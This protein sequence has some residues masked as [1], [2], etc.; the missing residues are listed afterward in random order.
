MIVERKELEEIPAIPREALYE[1]IRRAG[2][3]DPW[4]SEE[5]ARRDQRLLASF[6]LLANRCSEGL[7][8]EPDD[9]HLEVAVSV[10]DEDLKAL[11]D[12]ITRLRFEIESGRSLGRDMEKQVR[13]FG[14]LFDEYQEMS[15]IRAMWNRPGERMDAADLMAKRYPQTKV[16]VVKL[17]TLKRKKRIPR[18]VP[19]PTVDP[20]A[21]LFVEQL[22]RMKGHLFDISRQRVWQIFKRAGVYAFYKDQGYPVPKNPL[23]HS[24]LSEVSN[25]VNRVQLYRL[26]GWKLRGTV[27]KYVHLKWDD[28]MSPLLKVA[29]SAPPLEVA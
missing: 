3:E 5:G 14:S 2:E 26:A 25:V 4:R 20:L 18:V 19:V 6:Y 1:M 13:E 24:R 22:Q 7:A 17:L 28:F 16:Y 8:V 21:P 23:R 15:G 12:Y 27:D 11:S 10:L 29:R 9:I